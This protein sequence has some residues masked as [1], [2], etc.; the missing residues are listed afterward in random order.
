MTILARPSGL[1]LLFFFAGLATAADFAGAFN[2]GAPFLRAAQRAFIAAA[3]FARPSGVS[4]CLLGVAA[5]TTVFGATAGFPFDFAHLARCPAAMR[6][7]AAADILRLPFW[8]DEM[9]C[10]PAIAGG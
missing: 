3:N 5:F 7:R 6:S 8:L 1:S 4:P 2:A 9:S 10:N